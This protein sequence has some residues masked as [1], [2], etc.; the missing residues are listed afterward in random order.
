MQTV[1]TYEIEKHLVDLFS[2]LTIKKGGAILDPPPSTFYFDLSQENE[3]FAQTQP[4]T[5]LTV[6]A[7]IPNAGIRDT[8][9]VLLH[10][11]AAATALPDRQRLLYR[12]HM[13]P[14]CHQI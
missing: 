12:K 2:S 9:K 14:T 3:P 8:F 6:E 10:I 13:K 1:H 5:E 4:D 11:L 7:D